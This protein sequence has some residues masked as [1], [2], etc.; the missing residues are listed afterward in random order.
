M[1]PIPTRRWLV[2]AALLAVVAPV[3][4]VRPGAAGLLPALDL[5][6]VA[7]L[8]VVWLGTTHPRRP[9]SGWAGRRRCA[10][11]GAIPAVGR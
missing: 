1:I 10:T 3:A 4:L 5:L 7:A 2:G 11:A 8:R 9:H 6:W